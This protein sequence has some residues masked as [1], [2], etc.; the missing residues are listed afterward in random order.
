MFL[1]IQKPKNLKWKDN[2]KPW[3]RQGF[4]V[5]GGAGAAQCAARVLRRKTHA[6]PANARKNLQQY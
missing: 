3:D 6:F 5:G 1:K 2:L 4:F